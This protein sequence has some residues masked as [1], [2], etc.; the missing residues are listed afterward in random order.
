MRER[1]EEFIS[2]CAYINQNAQNMNGE[3][4]KK[5]KEGNP[6]M[7]PWNGSSAKILNLDLDEKGKHN[8]QEKSETGGKVRE[9]EGKKRK[10]SPPPPVP[11]VSLNL[12]PTHVEKVGT[13]QPPHLPLSITPVLEPGSK[14]ETNFSTSERNWGGCTRVLKGVNLESLKSGRKKNSFKSVLY[15]RIVEN[16]KLEVEHTEMCRVDVIF[17]KEE[18]LYKRHVLCGCEGGYVLWR[19]ETERVGGGQLP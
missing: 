17:Q 5:E 2:A 1:L 19:R 9:T 7:D 18:R 8:T 14:V 4:S 6:H 3:N 10:P 12:P 16:Q 15:P 11:P 13:T